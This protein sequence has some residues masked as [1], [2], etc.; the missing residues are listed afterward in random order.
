MAPAT[1][2]EPPLS[3][4]TSRPDA[5]T[6]RD[7]LLFA[8]TD[9][10]VFRE[11]EVD[12]YDGPQLQFSTRGMPASSVI[13][14]D[15]EE[16]ALAV[17]A[18]QMVRRPHSQT[19][20]HERAENGGLTA[21]EGPWKLNLA[22]IDLDTPICAIDFHSY[23]PQSSKVSASL[24]E[25]AHSYYC[26]VSHI[27]QIAA[28]SQLGPGH[29]AKVNVGQTMWIAILGGALLDKGRMT[30]QNLPG[31]W[32]VKGLSVDEAYLDRVQA[33]LDAIEPYANTSKFD[34]LVFSGGAS[35]RPTY[36]FLIAGLCGQIIICY[37]LSVGTSAGVWTSVAIA[38]SL[39]TGRLTDWHTMF[40]GRT[41]RTSEPGMKMYVPESPSKEIMV[42]ATLDRSSPRAEA[43]LSPGFLLNMCGLA[44]AVFGAVFQDQ[45]RASLGFG[46]QTATAK[47]VVYTSIALSLG[48]SF[49]I[50]L[51][52]ALQQLREHTWSNDMREAD[53]L[54][55]LQQY[56]DI[57]GDM[58][59]LQFSLCAVIL[60]TYGL[61]WMP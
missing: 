56:I 19:A 1:W 4:K 39:Y 49:L 28:T 48:I 14:V 58:Q 9:Y 12:I 46:R 45:T 52:T 7:F 13:D 33:V 25:L 54:G 29:V 16:Q 31:L 57:I 44:A 2:T 32:T 36:A 27:R 38:N 35:R 53:P 20:L 10:H 51:L 59:P 21:E 15:S 3:D 47:W 37:F 43:G 22:G 17:V 42:V 8:A 23:S 11:C 61:S 34:D 5:P 60:S 18:A 40:F 41:S 30:F 55:N 50:F 6:A 26:V 24:R